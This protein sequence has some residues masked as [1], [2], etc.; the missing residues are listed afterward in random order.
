M[1]DTIT[2]TGLR[3]RGLKTGLSGQREGRTVAV[4]VI[5][6]SALLVLATTVLLSA[7]AASSACG[8]RELTAGES[9][10]RVSALIVGTTHLARV[11]HVVG[12]GH[13]TVV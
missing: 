2:V 10:M 7:S 8:G 3:Q 6:T 12:T 9:T 5:T 1:T 4:W 11:E 13:C